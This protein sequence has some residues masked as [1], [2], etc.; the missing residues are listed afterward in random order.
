MKR[1]QAERLARLDR[2]QE[3]ACAAKQRHLA[4]M[5]HLAHVDD[6]IAR[7]LVGNVPQAFSH[8]GLI[9]TAFILSRDRSTAAA[10]NRTEHQD[11]PPA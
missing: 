2:V 6:P 4:R 11:D 5:V 8:I 7:R 10:K 3:R 1:H 9:N